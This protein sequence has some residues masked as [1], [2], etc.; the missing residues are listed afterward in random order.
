MGG[1]GGRK[2]RGRGNSAF[3]FLRG[4]KGTVDRADSPSDAP[5]KVTANVNQCFEA[6]LPSNLPLSPF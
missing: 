1:K 4:Q 2:G 3:P 5:L 6:M